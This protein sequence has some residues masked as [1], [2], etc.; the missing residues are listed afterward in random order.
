MNGCVRALSCLALFCVAMTTLNQARPE[1]VRHVGLDFWNLP[2]L[3]QEEQDSARR[4]AELEASDPHLLV[5]CGARARIVERVADGSMSLFA[6]ASAFRT[7][8]CGS[9][10]A[11]PVTFREQYPTASDEEC[12]CRQV[13]YWSGSHL[14]VK[15]DPERAA[16]VVA[17]LEAV[18]EEHLRAGKSIVLPP[19]ESQ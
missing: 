15:G 2:D 19:T 13:I 16:E 3:R 7:M 9:G 14:Q 10:T 11:V 18:L 12:L 17:R 6:A 5:N 8:N 4:L 1:W